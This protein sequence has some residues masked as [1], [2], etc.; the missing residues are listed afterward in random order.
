MA[1]QQLPISNDYRQQVDTI[2]GAQRVRVK[3]WW[4]PRDA[5]YF[6]MEFPI[7]TPIITGRR[8]NVGSPLVPAFVSFVGNITCQRLL[9][10]S[11]EPGADEPWSSTHVLVYE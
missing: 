6:T 8:I 11:G 9:D 5:W 3:V 4:Q 2:L 7:G 10:D 1:A